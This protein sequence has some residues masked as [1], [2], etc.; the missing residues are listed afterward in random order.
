MF[1]VEHCGGIVRHLKKDAW[2][3]MAKGAAGV[4]F[5][6]GRP[7]GSKKTEVQS[8]IFDRDNFTVE[9]ARAWL[10]RNDFSAAKI[11]ETSTSYRF[12]Q[13]DPGEFE[14]GSFRTITPGETTKSRTAKTV[15]ADPPAPNMVDWFKSLG[16]PGM[17]CFNTC[18][19]KLTNFMDFDDAFAVTCY[20]HLMAYGNMDHEPSMEGEIVSRDALKEIDP[21]LAVA[22]GTGRTQIVVRKPTDMETGHINDMIMGNEDG[23]MDSGGMGKDEEVS[24]LIAKAAVIEYEPKELRFSFVCDTVKTEEAAVTKNDKGEDVPGKKYVVGVATDPRVDKDKERMSERAVAEMGAQCKQGS[25]I[26]LPSHQA[27]TWKDGMGVVVDSHIGDNNE[28]MIKAELDMENE[29]SQRLWDALQKGKQIG[30]SVGGYLLRLKQEFNTALGRMINVIDGVELEHIAVTGRPANPR[31]WIQALGKTSHDYVEK[32]K[33]EESQMDKVTELLAELEKAIRSKDTALVGTITKS[34]SEAIGQREITAG[35]AQ[36]EATKTAETETAQ[37]LATLQKKVDDGS[38]PVTI[39]ATREEV[40]ALQK[41]RANKELEANPLFGALKTLTDQVSTLT[42][43]HADLTAEVAK[44]KSLNSS[45]G[46]EI[47]LLTHEEIT[48]TVRSEEIALQKTEA[49]LNAN[50]E[51]R[52]EMMG[53]AFR[54]TLRKSRGESADKL[55]K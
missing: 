51:Q 2:W 53:K 45:G 22:V 18:L 31:T 26:L 5:V 38:R 12:R 37:H 29:N 6:I 44:R 50:V 43:S 48:K 34:L 42:K 13:R 24:A 20:L 30:L 8:V 9:E 36:A 14:E 27:E 15:S 41:I 16:Q 1:H 25:V 47:D 4:K 7:K 19:Y 39:T 33:K 17:E 32:V 3:E 46:F 49:F 40:E 21:Y 35:K 10:E 52:M 11:D 55:E 23:E 28:L 54:N